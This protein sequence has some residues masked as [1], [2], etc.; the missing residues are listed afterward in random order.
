MK[1]NSISELEKLFKVY[2]CKAKISEASFIKTRYIDQIT[3]DRL[4]RYELKFDPYVDIAERCSMKLLEI[5]RSPITNRFYIGFVNIGGHGA[6]WEIRPVGLLEVKN[7][8]YME[9]M[10]AKYGQ[11]LDWDIDLNENYEI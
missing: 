8:Q 4:I 3:Y 7:Y 2:R 1:I 10:F 9:R 5:M 6:R 11:Q